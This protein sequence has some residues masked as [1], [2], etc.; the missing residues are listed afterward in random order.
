MDDD[1]ERSRRRPDHISRREW[2][3]AYSAARTPAPSSSGASLRD[4]QQVDI[5]LSVERLKHD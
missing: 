4:V 3:E 1:D 2:F 5:G